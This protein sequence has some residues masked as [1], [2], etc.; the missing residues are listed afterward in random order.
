MVADVIEQN[1]QHLLLKQ[2]EKSLTLALH[3]YLYAFFTAGMISKQWKWFFK[4]S[5]WI[6]LIED[7]SLAL[8]EY[9]FVNKN[10]EQIELQS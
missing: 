3:P 2:N 5:K 7:S 6:K 1:V 8:A 9:T 4:Y 10:G